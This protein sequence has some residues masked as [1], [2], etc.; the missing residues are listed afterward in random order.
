MSTVQTPLWVPL[1]LAVIALIG[2][3]GAAI[4]TSRNNN[5]RWEKEHTAVQS[6]ESMQWR[7]DKFRLILDSKVAWRELRLTHYSR[8]LHKMDRMYRA[9]V[10]LLVDKRRKKPGASTRDDEAFLLSEDI[11]LDLEE[12]MLISGDEVRKAVYSLHAY[13]MKML[14]HLTTPTGGHS[15]DLLDKATEQSRLYE[16][17]LTVVRRVI[18]EDI[19]AEVSRMIEIKDLAK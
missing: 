16:E 5:R 9:A 1:V 4:V 8:M 10:V 17:Q 15:A 13:L 11:R 19:A 14:Q 18:R 12:L 6:R 7:R 3:I 2:P